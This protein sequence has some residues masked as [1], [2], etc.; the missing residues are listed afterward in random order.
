MAVLT[1]LGTLVFALTMT[2]V[3]IMPAWGR[4]A[5]RGGLLLASGVLWLA[6]AST[7]GA[8]ADVAI[9]LPMMRQ[10]S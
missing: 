7:A 4:M 5:A 6:A 10:M 8:G 3:P 1:I 9:I 2:L